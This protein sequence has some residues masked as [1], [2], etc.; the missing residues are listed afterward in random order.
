MRFTFLVPAIFLTSTI[1]H[2]EQ[3][4]P[5][6]LESQAI[7]PAASFVA[8]PKDAPA[9]LKT[10]G[11]FAGKT[12]TRIEKL[13]STPGMDGK[14]AT[15][16]SFPFNGQP[17]Q[18]F[19]G[20]RAMGDGTFWIVTD[21]G[22][23][24][25]VNS[26]DA[27]LMINRYSV[28]WK[29]GSVSPIENVFLH[30]P[31]RIIP[32]HIVNE[33]TEK[34][35][36]TGG[37]LDLESFQIIDG[38][39]W[40]GEE[41]GPYLIRTDKTGKVEAIFETMVDGKPVMSPDNPLVRTPAAPGGKVA[42]NVRR[43]KGFEGMA[44]S[45][46]GRFL[47]ALLEGALWDDTKNA[48]EQDEGKEY[49][50]ILEFDVANQKWT[51]RFWKYPLAVN[52]HS[53]GDFNMIDGTTALI[54]ERDDGEGTVDQACEPTKTTENCFPTL[55]KFKRVYKI[56]MSDTTAGQAVKKI[57][58][59]DLLEIEDKANIAKDGTKNGVFKFPF[60]TIENVDAIDADHIIV[61][62]D[63]NLPFSAGRALNKADNNELILLKV[64]EFLKAR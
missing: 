25:K 8:A 29:T 47:Y 52:G 37:D 17:L 41:F 27:M 14:R 6:Q 20:I 61:G 62:N 4:Y 5:A 49:L 31:D 24:N 2:A 3:K 55:A 45:K 44:A 59:I 33:A 32:F 53:I 40:F 42:F 60:F 38:K 50:R 7:F 35:Y 34:R 48:L 26:T 18:G 58:Y 23:G 51:G 10:S 43:S 64:S 21:N 13:D 22:F 16:L 54:I 39:F 46:D 12:P 11:K 28:D 36:L 56:E 9:S 30:D 19:S 15:G 63:N 57:G 1:A